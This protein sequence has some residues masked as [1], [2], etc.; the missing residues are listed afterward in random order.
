[1]GYK[2]K[3]NKAVSKRYK[4]TATGK[5]LSR[6]SGKKHI[7]AKMSSKRKRT[8]RGFKVLAKCNAKRLKELLPYS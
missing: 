3:T 5:F 8:L 2:Q 7:N 6:Q 1:M 4:K